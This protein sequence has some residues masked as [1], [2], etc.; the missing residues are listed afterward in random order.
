MVVLKA[1]CLTTQAGPPCL[2]RPALPTPAA[3]HTARHGAV[4][5]STAPPHRRTT[6][7]GTAQHGAALGSTAQHHTTPR[8]PVRT[9][10]PLP[11]PAPPRTILHRLAQHS[12]APAMPWGWE[13]GA[14][15]QIS[16]H[17]LCC[18]M[19]QKV[20]MP[21]PIAASGSPPLASFCQALGL[22]LG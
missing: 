6:Q 2:L 20:E 21:L 19:P 10:L 15:A 1:R 18:A 5:H 9:P 4:Q 16:S 3:P 17:L 22:G 13:G 8:C 14:L 7:H 11:H 12:T